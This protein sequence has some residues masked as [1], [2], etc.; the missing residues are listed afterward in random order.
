MRK[1]T[2]KPPIDTRK[3]TDRK[4][5]DILAQATPSDLIQTPYTESGRIATPCVEEWVAWRRIKAQ[6]VDPTGRE[7]FQPDYSIVTCRLSWGS[8]DGCLVG[9]DWSTNPK[10]HPCHTDTGFVIHVNPINQ[11]CYQHHRLT[12]DISLHRR[13]SR[14]SS[15]GVFTLRWRCR[16]KKANQIASLSINLPTKRYGNSPQK[17]VG[18]G[19]SYFVFWQVRISIFRTL[20]NLAKK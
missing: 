10:R 2:S 19:F 9:C 5:L 11:Q 8:W 7:T 12:P 20:A 13:G 15:G 4:K 17:K 1:N 18:Q 3:I 6:L 16:A 14:E